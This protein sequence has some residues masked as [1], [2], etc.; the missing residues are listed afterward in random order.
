[1]A[2]TAFHMF[3]CVA[4][5]LVIAKAPVA[6][7]YQSFYVPVWLGLRR[8]VVEPLFS[9][10]FVVVAVCTGMSLLMLL[11]YQHILVLMADL[12]GP[13]PLALCQTAT[14]A[15][16]CMCRHMHTHEHAHAHGTT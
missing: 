2:K 1:L 8:E 3:L 10:S 5:R 14:T 13:A 9:L 4:E 11:I 16:T 15:T 12:H 6:V 7:N